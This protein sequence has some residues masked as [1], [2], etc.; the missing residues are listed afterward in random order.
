MP[1]QPCSLPTAGA[2]TPVTAQGTAF[3]ACAEVFAQIVMLELLCPGLP[4]IAT[5]LLF[6]M[7]MQ[8]TYTLQ[9]NTEITIA[10]LIAMEL[11]ERGYNIRAHSYG[12]GT[13]SLT[14]DAQNFI[15]RTSLTDAMAM[16][17]A[18]V[19]GGAGQ[20]ETAKTISPLQLIID[21]EIFGIAQRIRKGLDVNDETLD[22]DEIIAGIDMDPAFS[23]LMSEH[24]FRHYEEPHR[25]DMFNRD[26]VARWE[27]EGSKDL[28][29]KAREKFDAIM[30]AE[31][32][33]ALPADKAAA[34]EEV[35]KAAHAALVK[36]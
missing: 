3:M 10:R 15:E 7:D 33:Y 24:T 35:L 9:S 26:G 32:T 30:A 1:V 25:P 5:T 6:S 18:S 19:L 34:V 29:T 4:V 13:D 14:M 20:L 8:S 22:W 2:N 17:E 31:D 11:F 28:L 36:E 27:M 21:N 12:T 16:S 23:F